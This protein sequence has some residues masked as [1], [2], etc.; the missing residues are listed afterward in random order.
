MDTGSAIIG[1]TRQKFVKRS[2]GNFVKSRNNYNTFQDYIW[3][4]LNSWC[5]LIYV[6]I[7]FHI[8]IS[9]HIEKKTTENVLK[10]PKRTKIIVISPK[11]RF[12]QK[13]NLCRKVYRGLLMYQISKIY[14]DLWGHNC[15][16]WV[17]PIFSCK[18]GQRDPVVMKL[19]LGIIRPIFKRAYEIEN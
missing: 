9:N 17:W 10:N 16:K 4:Q 2:L 18:A 8:D 5:R 19:K 14:L 7:K 1:Q 6:Y 15:K 11:I 12:L 13:K 3:L